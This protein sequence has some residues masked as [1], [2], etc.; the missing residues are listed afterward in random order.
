MASQIGAAALAEPGAEAA[1]AAAAR[2]ST[3]SA[4]SFALALADFG[5]GSLGAGGADGVVETKDDDG[6]EEDDGV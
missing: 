1:D 3:G 2:L 5:T 6:A 4:S